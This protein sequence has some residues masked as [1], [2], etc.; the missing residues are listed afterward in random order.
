MIVLVIRTGRRF[1]ART[2]VAAAAV[3][4]STA[5]AAAARYTRLAY[6][7]RLSGEST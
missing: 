4:D 1:Y 2:T 3:Y 7:V 6:S 5:A